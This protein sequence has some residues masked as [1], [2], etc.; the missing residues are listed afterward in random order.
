MLISPRPYNGGLR[1]IE[2]SALSGFLSSLLTDYK[3]Q[4]ERH[5]N[6]PF[7][8]GTMAACALIAIA[9]G[10]VSFAERIRVDQIFAA[11]DA[12]KIFDPHEAVD[13]FNGFCADII[14]SPQQG[15]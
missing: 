8:D 11:L 13:I 12:L 7:L 14:D 4:V 6:R 10:E 1:K 2:A 15:L 5:K 3:K 9:D